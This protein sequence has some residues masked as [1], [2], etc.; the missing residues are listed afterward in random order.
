MHILKAEQ[1]RGDFLT[2]CVIV[3]LKILSNQYAHKNKK[4]C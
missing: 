3:A 2:E 4:I 1:V